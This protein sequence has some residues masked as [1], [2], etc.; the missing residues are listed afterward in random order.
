MSHADRSES[1]KD[2]NNEA[3]NDI[4]IAASDLCC[5]AWLW[6]AAVGWQAL[7]PSLNRLARSAPAPAVRCRR[8]QARH[9][10]F[11]HK[12]AHVRAP[13]CLEALSPVQ[14]HKSFSISTGT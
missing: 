8:S 4:L 5:G 14:H 11:R 13:K 7:G 9:P 12:A 3:R 2:T 1:D 10:P 6:C